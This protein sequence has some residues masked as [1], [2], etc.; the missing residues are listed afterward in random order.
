MRETEVLLLGK[1]R[2][3]GALPPQL[4][5]R[6]LTSRRV[7]PQQPQNLFRAA[8]LNGLRATTLML[9]GLSGADDVLDPGA[10]Q[11]EANAALANDQRQ[12]VVGQDV[13]IPGQ[14]TPYD[15]GR[16]DAYTEVGTA[17]VEGATKALKVWIPL[18]LLSGALSAWHGYK[19]DRTAIA[20]WGWFTL[21]TMFPL[22]TPAVAVAQG[23][24]KSRRGG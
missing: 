11:A 20:G 24:G 13:V 9:G 7:T 2:G 3:F 10:A 12:T 23:F 19:R 6:Q 8:T 18:S 21:G 1:T 22:I 15:R 5:V 4:R 16:I 17:A 14:P